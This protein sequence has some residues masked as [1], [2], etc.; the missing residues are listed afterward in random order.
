M[1]LFLGGKEKSGVVDLIEIIAE[2]GCIL[3]LEVTFLEYL[4][5]WS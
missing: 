1:K 2:S 5:E 3:I 4:C